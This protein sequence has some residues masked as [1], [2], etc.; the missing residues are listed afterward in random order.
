LLFSARYPYVHYI[1]YKNSAATPVAPALA[2]GHLR[3]NLD[4]KK[5]RA[6]DTLLNNGRVPLQPCNELDTGFMEILK[7]RG[8]QD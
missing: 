6:H 7:S 8:K 5:Q 3:L 1:V 4:T 2:G